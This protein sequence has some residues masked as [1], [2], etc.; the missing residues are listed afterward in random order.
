MG[1]LEA[2]SGMRT[3]TVVCPARGL[4]A[5]R[6]SEGKG[7]SLSPLADDM[8]QVGDTSAVSAHENL[9]PY[10]TVLASNSNAA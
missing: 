9:A 6:V 3:A 10:E 7:R 5:S 4:P 1:T 8:L 2:A